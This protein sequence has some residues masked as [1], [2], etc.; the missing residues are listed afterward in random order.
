MIKNSVLIIITIMF[1][2][3]LTVFLI[4]IKNESIKN[5]LVP[6]FSS[7]ISGAITLISVYWTIRESERKY[8]V[9]EARKYKPLF[10]FARELEGINDKRT[11]VYFRKDSE[12][13]TSNRLG[14]IINSD[15]NEF[16]IKSIIL[17]DTEYKPTNNSI[18]RKEHEIQLYIREVGIDIKDEFEFIFVVEDLLGNEYNYKVVTMWNPNNSTFMIEDIKEI[19]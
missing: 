13:K 6:I 11:N 17:N 15:K 5:V 2:A 19:L 1:L 18:A 10:T 12:I 14:M 3:I 4:N 9:Q 8:D 7:L 16:I